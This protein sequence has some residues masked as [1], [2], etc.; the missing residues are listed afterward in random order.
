[1]LYMCVNVEWKCT[2]KI[3]AQQYWA[4]H[5]EN[6]F[7][8]HFQSNFTDSL[9]ITEFTVC[10]KFMVLKDHHQNEIKLRTKEIN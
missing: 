3:A 4:I 9:R 1:M 2:Y 6:C 5:N 10:Q 8:C 7:P